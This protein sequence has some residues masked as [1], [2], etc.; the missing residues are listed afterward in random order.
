MADLWADVT[1]LRPT[2]SE[3]PEPPAAS[4]PVD[5]VLLGVVRRLR[6]RAESQAVLAERL[7]SNETRPGALA[8]LAA[9]GASLRGIR[10][11]SETLLALSGAAAG[12]AAGGAVPLADLLREAVSA[13]D[14]PGRIVVAPPA[15][16]AVVAPTSGGLVL[17]LA[18]LL[19]QATASRSPGARIEVVS[20]RSGD[21]GLVVEV[22]APG[23]GPAPD[24]AADLERGLTTGLPEG[25]LAAERIGV[26]VAARL[27]HSCGLRVGL[28][29][30]PGVEAPLGLAL[31]G[32]VHCPS[33]LLGDRGPAR[34]VE[35]DRPHVERSFDPP[36]AARGVD[37]LFG[38]LDEV[39]PQ[40]ADDLSDTPIYA[41]VASAWFERPNRSGGRRGRGAEPLDWSSQGDAEWRAAAERA[42]RA[43]QVSSLTSSGLPRRR[44]GQQMVAPPRRAATTAH[45]GAADRAPDL[46]RMRLASYQRGLQEGRHRAVDPDSPDFAAS[47]P[48]D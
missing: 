35:P 18:E 28:V 11:D 22:F 4:A 39:A 14:E 1:P 8:D 34:S 6:A 5:E 13:A 36:P 21:G 20:R 7:R 27:A 3:P 42:S 10:R 44:P 25:P 17:V 23:A 40:P 32:A 38:P 41:A 48:D 26:F 45:V 19:G 12:S 29:P 47:P 37:E 2:R 15:Q 30:D 9:L 43:D 24:E 16:A 33:R 46:V 31:V